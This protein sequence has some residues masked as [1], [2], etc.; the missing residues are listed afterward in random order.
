MTR[1]TVL[2]FTECY[3]FRNY[4]EE[5]FVKPDIEALSREFD[6]VVLL[7]LIRKDTMCHVD[8][9]NVIVDTT[10]ADDSGIQN[11][12]MKRLWLLHP[13]TLK[14]LI[15]AFR[16]S[17]T[18]NNK[19]LKNIVTYSNVAYMSRI[20][21]SVLKRYEATSTSVTAYTFWFDTVTSALAMLSPHHTGL[22]I[23]SRAHGYDI[24]D[25]IHSAPHPATLRN[26]TL[27]RMSGVCA[28]S[29]TSA[30]YLRCRFPGHKDIIR[31]SRLG[32]SKPDNTVNAG[33][34][35]GDNVITI[36]SVARV[37]PVKRVDRNLALVT[38]IAKRHPELRINWIHVGDGSLMNEL[39]T[40]LS[41]LP[42][43]LDVDL[44]GKLDNSQVHAI[45]REIPIDW[46]ILLSD[47]EGG[48]PITIC[49]SLS[50]SIPPV[51]TAV[52]GTPEIVNSSNGIPVDMNMSYEKIA[53]LID[54][55]IND[56]QAYMQLKHNA[57]HTWQANLQERDLREQFAKYLSSLT[58]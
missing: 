30:N 22:H 44:R 50:Y 15:S 7:P 31:T 56:R 10:L 3:P 53:D 2:L 37:E 34:S 47:S 41:D 27:G 1:R 5:V 12:W 39:K 21:G 23:V 11:R 19:V 49:E 57:L 45:Y 9:P 42:D 24:Y 40:N 4:T 29:E 8:I 38:E 17:D 16:D 35:E 13:F 14:H 20:I 36:M 48:A 51:A 33:H 25:N 58:C 43:N 26:M 18:P 6:Q 55:Y 46:T 32:S 28:A 54:R 52:G